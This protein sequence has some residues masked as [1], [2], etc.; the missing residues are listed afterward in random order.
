MIKKIL[1]HQPI[2]RFPVKVRKGV[3]KGAWWTLYPS[4]SYWRTGGGHPAIDQVIMNYACKP[5]GVAWDLGAHFGIYTVGMARHVGDAG[6]I[7]AFEPDAISRARLELHISR[8]KLRNVVVVAAAASSTGGEAFLLQY[9]AFGN[10]TSHLA[11]PGEN[12]SA[13]PLKAS[14]PCVAIDDLV[15]DGKIRLPQFVK[16]DVEGHGGK[17]LEG[18]R[19]SL[20]KSRPVI[21]MAFHEGAENTETAAI[22]KDLNYDSHELTGERC[23]WPPPSYFGD[24][25]LLPAKYE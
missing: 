15:A 12:T 6:Q 19:H 20:L 5:G 8:N 11:F 1:S 16:I 7:V 23:D 18:M 25:L 2:S 14:I 21:L 13:V 3:A 17:A 24:L 10:T 4:S 22:L 9:G